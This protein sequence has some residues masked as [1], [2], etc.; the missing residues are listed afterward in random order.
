MR[1][2]TFEE[3]EDLVR[4]AGGELLD[5]VSELQQLGKK[6]RLTHQQILALWLR[7]PKETDLPVLPLRHALAEQGIELTPQEAT[8][9]V[10][11]TLCK[12]RNFLRDSG[13]TPPDSDREMLALLRQ[14][15]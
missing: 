7:A 6:H 12:V 14:K 9:T 10:E 2:L 15:S 3:R 1:P 13:E 5:F 8:D 4:R 11:L